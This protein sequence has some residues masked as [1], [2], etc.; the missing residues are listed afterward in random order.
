MKR[1]YVT[2][3]IL[4]PVFVSGCI[5]PFP[6]RRLHTYGMRGSVV[7]AETNLPIP[8]AAVATCA[9]SHCSVSGDASGQFRMKPVHGWHAVYL[10][11]SLSLS[12]F[13]GSESPSKIATVSVSAPGYE[14]NTF[15]LSHSLSMGS[16]N[17]NGHIMVDYQTNDDYVD[18]DPLMLRRNQ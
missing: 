2:S 11:G 18:V 7:D 4:L 1:I 13:S 14:T 8:G 5:I 10:I 16:S 15:D 3:V 17:W 9:V 12:L 6:R